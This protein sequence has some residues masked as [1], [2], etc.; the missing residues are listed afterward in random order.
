MKV[1]ARKLR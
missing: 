1:K